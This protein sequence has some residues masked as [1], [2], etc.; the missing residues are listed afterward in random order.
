MRYN[1]PYKSNLIVFAGAGASAGLGMPTTPEFVELLGEE[2]PQISQLLKQYREYIKDIGESKNVNEP[3]DAEELR[4]WLIHLEQEAKYTEYL[5]K[6]QPFETKVPNT[7]SASQ[8]LSAVLRDFDSKIRRTYGTVNPGRANT[9]YSEFFKLLAQFGTDLVPF[10][11]TNYDLVIES[12]EEYEGFRWD[13]ETGMG[14]KGTNVVLNTQRFEKVTSGQPTILLF[15]LHGSTDWWR[16]KQTEQIVQ[17]SFDISP[18]SH[19]SDLLI[20]PTRDKFNQVTEQPFSFFYNMLESFLS[21]EQLRLCIAI[22][23][24][25]RD[26]V[27]NEKFSAALK[28]G[29]RLLILDPNMKKAQLKQAF[30]M[31]EIDNQIR[32]ENVRF[33]DWSPP[34]RNR[35]AEVLGEEFGNFDKDGGREKI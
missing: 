32:I 13:I 8:F 9:H 27:V 14:K 5:L 17:V 26:R 33:G 25:F 28:G 1:I 11:T 23:Y 29:L 12:L 31:P 21:S 30:D 6:H 4:D 22:G 19:Y 10:F 2:W 20:Y 7:S 16:N 35:I 18:P 15:K 3:I 24:S 34:R